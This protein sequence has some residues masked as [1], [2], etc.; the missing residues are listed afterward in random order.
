MPLGREVDLCPGEIVLDGTQ[1]PLKG[2]QPPPQFLAHVCC[3]QTAGW[4][5]VPLGK[6]VGLSPGHIVSD[7]DPTPPK[8]GHSN[9]PTFWPVSTVAELSLIAATDP[10]LLALGVILV[11]YSH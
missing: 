10:H 9:H 1:L 4:I 3:G 6:E 8:K 11:F 7:G 5:K 2:A